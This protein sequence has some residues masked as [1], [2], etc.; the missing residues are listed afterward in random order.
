MN[1]KGFVST[2]LIITTIILASAIILLMIFKR[3]T[4]SS[5]ASNIATSIKIKLSQSKEPNCFWGSAPYMTLYEG[6][7]TSTI[8][9]S[10]THIDGIL[11]NLPA[12]L[13]TEIIPS[14]FIS[15]YKENGVQTNDLQIKLVRIIPII[16]GY[17]IVIEVKSNILGNYYL[18]LNKEQIYTNDN[19][20]NST[21]LDSKYIQVDNRRD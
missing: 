4:N 17:K 1:N 5:F 12:I 19:Y 16:N 2:A 15:I 11:T 10:C 21:K 14:T 9:L 20:P 7:A 13:N 8:L 6:T 18:R 3:E